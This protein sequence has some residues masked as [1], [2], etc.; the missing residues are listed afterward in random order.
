MQAKLKK[1]SGCDEIKHIW[2]KHNRNLYCK[3]CWYRHPE[4]RKTELERRKEKKLLAKKPLNKKSSKQEKL[5][6]IYLLLRADYLKANRFCKAKLSGCQLNAT[7]IHHKAGRGK[8]ML[9]Q[10]TFLAVC[11][12]C[13]NQIEENP[14]MAKEMGFS[15]SREEAHG[16]KEQD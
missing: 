1:C 9:D 4:S 7:D 10:S 11:R 6:A 16:N 12:I 2:K 15:L 5:N 13:H 3:D 8:F 14:I